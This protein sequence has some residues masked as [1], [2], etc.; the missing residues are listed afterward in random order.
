MEEIGG[1]IAT[2]KPAQVSE[3]DTAAYARQQRMKAAAMELVG[4]VQGPT[5]RILV[6]LVGNSWV[7]KFVG[8]HA[9][10]VQDLF[11]TDTL[12]LPFTRE[13]PLKTVIETLKKK[14]PGVEI[15]PGG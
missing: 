13:A 14:N 12:P 11:R 8:P 6:S 5:N 10:R 7:A 1:P 9:A 4:G 15:I 3:E 2:P